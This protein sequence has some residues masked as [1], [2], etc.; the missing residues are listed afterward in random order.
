ML[1]LCDRL[2][3]ALVLILTVSVTLGDVLQRRF[4]LDLLS[5]ANLF[6]ALVTI[7]SHFFSLHSGFTSQCQAEAINHQAW[8]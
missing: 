5:S 8:V 6:G 7:T 2:A 1:L 3:V 4:F